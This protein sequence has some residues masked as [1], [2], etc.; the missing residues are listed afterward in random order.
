LWRNFQPLFVAQYSWKARLT[1]PLFFLPLFFLAPSLAVANRYTTIDAKGIHTWSGSAFRR[2]DHPLSAVRE[3]VSLE[4]QTANGKRRAA[5]KLVLLSDNEILTSDSSFLGPAGHLSDFGRR[6]RQAL[7][8][9]AALSHRQART[10]VLSPS[11]SATTP[12]ALLQ[13][14]RTHR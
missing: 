3:I 11:E 8:V 14:L 2:V 9:L 4:R 6:P 1:S 5:T 7:D 13:I 10:V 12:D